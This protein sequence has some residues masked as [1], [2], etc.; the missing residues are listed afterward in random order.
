MVPHGDPVILELLQRAG[1]QPK[2]IGAILAELE[3]ELLSRAGTN[4]LLEGLQ[5]VAAVSESMDAKRP[6]LARALR[7][8][9]AKQAI[10]DALREFSDELNAEKQMDLAQKAEDFLRFAGRE[11]KMQARKFEDGPVSSAQTVAQ[12]SIPRRV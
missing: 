8:L 9:M 5:T 3:S 10:L 11:G 4:A 2:K 6:K 1:A 7:C 12:F